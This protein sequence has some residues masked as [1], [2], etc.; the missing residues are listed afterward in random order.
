M[1]EFTAKFI[2]L[3][4]CN[5]IPECDDI[6]NAFSK[7]L[8]C[9]NF[10]TEFVMDPKGDNQK[11]I[12]VNINQNFDYWKFDFILLLIEYY[13]K[14]TQTK[15][16]KAT[17]NILKWT[18]QYKENTDIYLNYLNENTEKN[19]NGH[20]HS[21][22]LYESF[23]IWFKINNPNT[24]IPCNKEFYNGIK[25]YHTMAPVKVSNKTQQGIKF[26]KILNQDLDQDLN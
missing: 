12:D 10:P 20:I 16:L 15:E 6:D 8:R 2:T 25:K 9:I 22:V 3:L 21:S 14:Y 1:I 13:K 26:L 4:I 11:K 7:R 19:E 23:K 17:A 24:K 18:D 5:D